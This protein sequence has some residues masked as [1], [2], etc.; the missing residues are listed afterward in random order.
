[1][2][3][4]CRKMQTLIAPIMVALFLGSLF[5]FFCQ[6]CLMK[7]EQSRQ[8]AIAS[9][10]DG[11]HCPHH[12]SNQPQPVSPA[13]P[14]TGVCD[15]GDHAMLIADQH[16]IAISDYRDYSEIMIL[17]PPAADRMNYAPGMLAYVIGKPAKPERACFT[18][19]ER[20]CVLL[21]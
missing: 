19:L 12:G 7:L 15:C 3:A 10:N 2:L 18:P 11:G 20:N 8:A 14:C 6:H 4:W 17:I 9:S 16:A 5:T 1:M 13:K 21:N